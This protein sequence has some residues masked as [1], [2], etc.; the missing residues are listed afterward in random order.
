[1]EELRCRKCNKLL[2]KAD[3]DGQV[4]ISCPRC[5]ALNSFCHTTFTLLSS[6]QLFAYPHLDSPLNKSIIKKEK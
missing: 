4:E 3:F 5:G 6:Y 1:M 2:A